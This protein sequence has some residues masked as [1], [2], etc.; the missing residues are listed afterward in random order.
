MSRLIT[1]ENA[2][3]YASE[4]NLM[5]ALEKTGLRDWDCARSIVVARTAEGRWTA[6]FVLDMSKGGYIA[7]ASALGFI[8]V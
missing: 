1:L 7:A 3:S 6:I 4:K 2:K 5:A 8:T